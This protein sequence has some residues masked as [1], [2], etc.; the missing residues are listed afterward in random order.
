MSAEDETAGAKPT[1]A[2][3]PP[4]YIAISGPIAVGKTTLCQQLGEVTKMAVGYE[5]VSDNPYLSDFYADPKRHSFATQIHFL[6]ER[7][8]QQK[9]IEADA[10]TDNDDDDDDDEGDEEYDRLGAVRSFIQDR[11]IFEDRVFAAVQLKCGQME[12]REYDTYTRIF[13]LMARESTVPHA[14]IYLDVRPETCSERIK[15][16]YAPARLLS[17]PH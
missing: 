13:S 4:W 6:T 8:E 17:S 5:N 10:D 7:L 16:R 11:T 14:V 12:Q 2:V 9:R 1:D 3:V 15:Q